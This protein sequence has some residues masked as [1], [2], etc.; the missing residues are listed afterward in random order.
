MNTSTGAGTSLGNIGF[1]SGGDLAFNGGNLFMSSTTNQLI[2]IDLTPV[3]SG[4]AVGPF[5]FTDVFGLATGQD[6][7]LY[8]VS[9]TQILSINTN[10]GA[11]TPVLNYAS[12]GLVQAFGASAFVV[13]EPSTLALFCV[14]GPGLL[15]WTWRRR[16]G[17]SQAEASG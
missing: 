2:K 5:G 8:G 14:C 10:T 15:A 4:T 3:V 17:E 1:F 9:G 11:G 6:G 13:P 7:V 16:H 12:S